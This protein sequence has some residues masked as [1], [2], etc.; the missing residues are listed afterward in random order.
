MLHNRGAA[1]A[2]NPHQLM[3]QA[4]RTRDLSDLSIGE[5]MKAMPAGGDALPHRDRW[6]QVG[7]ASDKCGETKS[8]EEKDG[9]HAVLTSN[10][11]QIAQWEAVRFFGDR[12]MVQQM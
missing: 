1:D 9:F 12:K 6:L 7:R 4:R 10:F 2:R 11:T 3:L 5:N 8:A